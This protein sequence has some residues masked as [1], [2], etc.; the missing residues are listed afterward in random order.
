M[1][2]GSAIVL[3]FHLEHDGQAFLTV[4][5]VTED[6]VTLCAAAGIVVFF[7]VC[8]LVCSLASSYV[9]DGLTVL[10]KSLAEHFCRKS[11]LHVLIAFNLL[12]LRLNE[13]FVLLA[14]FHLLILCRKSLR[15]QF[16]VKLR[17]GLVA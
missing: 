3:I 5:K 12:F 1:L 6:E 15:F 13:K 14:K 16:G 9:E 2:D 10:F 17:D 8:R 11:R 4:Y 7:E